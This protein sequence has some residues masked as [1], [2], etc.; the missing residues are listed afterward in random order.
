MAMITR[1]V[2]PLL[3]L[4]TLLACVIG[5]AE[6]QSTTR[7]VA[8]TY[9]MSL[10]SPQGALK[11]VVVVKRENNALT[12]TLAAEGYPVI[13]LTTV[14][15]SATGVT[16]AA[17]TPDG[18]LNMALTFGASEKVTGTLNYQGMDLPVEG[19]FTAGAA[20]ASGP[21]P[22]RPEVVRVL[23]PAVPAAR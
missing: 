22:S 15:P 17:D 19:T 10:N 5:A 4:L 12:G 16:I 1:S 9:T 2:R 20:P 23:T 6:A 18:G 21:A 7:E 8:G 13:P 11:I 3:R 14:T